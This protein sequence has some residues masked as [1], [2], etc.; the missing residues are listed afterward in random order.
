MELFEKN[1]WI[2]TVYL[3]LFSLVGL[4]LIVIG[5][6][7][8]IDLGLKI[9]IFKE[10]D[11]PE[12]ISY[13]IPYPPRPFIEPLPVK[14]SA[15]GNVELKKTEQVTEEEKQA[16]TQWI[17]DYQGWQETQS[18]IDY[19]RSRREREASSALAFIIVGVPLYLYHW[20]VIIRD[21]RKQHDA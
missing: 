12:S 13:G 3:Y 21:R 10:A 20:S 7:R 6:V 16:L 17:K 18:K 8:F 5:A 2:R 15:S 9:F 11:K 14:G 19:V 4:A 1:S